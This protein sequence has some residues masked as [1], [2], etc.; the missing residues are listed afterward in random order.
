MFVGQ[1]DLHNDG[2]KGVGVRGQGADPEESVAVVGC[3]G[4]SKECELSVFHPF[5]IHI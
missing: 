5:P 3:R 2:H 1:M 4:L